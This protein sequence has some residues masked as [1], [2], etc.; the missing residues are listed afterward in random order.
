MEDPDTNPDEIDLDDEDFYNYENEAVTEAAMAATMGF[1]S[2]G[3]S[4]KH[5]NS[6]PSSSTHTSKKRRFNPRA[7]DAVIAPP[8][9][10]GDSNADDSENFYDHEEEAAEQGNGNGVK[11]AHLTAYRGQLTAAAATTTTKPEFEED[12]IDY[13]DDDLYEDKPGAPS[14]SKEDDFE[15]DLTAVFDDS[16]D[17]PSSTVGTPLPVTTSTT[18]Q[19]QTKTKTTKLPDKPKT[20]IPP[21]PAA[22]SAGNNGGSSRPQ[23]N[24]NWYV[25]YYDPRSNANPWEAL[26]KRRGLSPVGTWLALPSRNGNGNGTKKGNGNRNGDATAIS[27]DATSTSALPADTAVADG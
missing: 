13:D 23:W 3:G 21:T 7:D 10:A 27:G 5:S 19:P 17:V 22:T 2:F 15:L 16:D 11:L 26:E 25:G 4:Q 14:A 12:L 6:N 1:S 20:T 24:P 18:S 8:E 9:P